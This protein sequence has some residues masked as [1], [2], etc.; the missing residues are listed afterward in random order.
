MN[1]ESMMKAWKYLTVDEK[2][3][4]LAQ[5]VYSQE[6]R[7]R[8]MYVSENHADYELLDINTSMLGDDVMLNAYNGNFVDKIN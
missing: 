5:V 1:R 3:E 2:L 6:L 8:E 4:R 7:I